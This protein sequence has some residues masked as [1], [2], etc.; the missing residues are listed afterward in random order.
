M[1]D[2]T[3]PERARPGR[4][5]SRIDGAALRADLRR[6]VPD[7][8]A[9]LV[10]T[11]VI[12]F[13]VYARI[14][15]GT[16][17]T[18]MVMPFLSDAREYWLYWL[19]QAFGWSGLLW[20]WITVMLGLLRSTAPPA[21]APVPHARIER[22]H[23]VTSLTTMGLMFAHAFAFFLE[24]VRDNEEGL[25]WGGRLLSA[26]VDV[27][28]PGGYATGTG[29]VAILI[30]LIALYLAVP[31]SLAY[32]F[33]FRTGTRTWRA[34]HRFVIVVYAL[35]VWHTLL[36]G[37]N[38]WFDGWF[39]TFVWALQL[40]VA[41]LLLARLLAP[42]RADER[43]T[44]RDLAGGRR[45]RALARLGA[46]LAVAATVVVLLV[47]TVTGRDGGR[48]PGAEGG[49]MLIGQDMVWGGLAVLLTVI[50]AVVLSLRG[51]ERPERGAR[52]G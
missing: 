43:F 14:E 26:F 32:Y 35:S 44:L 20:A 49:E 18:L 21:R 48:T 41:L 51:R 28:V 27:F 15:A 37:T 50:G 10:V 6:V 13:V 9:A 19:C 34:L 5:P 22:W 7:S 3:G 40:P 2:T 17:M 33:R 16:S 23:R 4:R 45:L 12:F 36:Y 25:A 38:V 52:V 42:L 1:A 47:V 39:R 8:A 24:L 11:L 31:L 29:Q 30:G 46:R